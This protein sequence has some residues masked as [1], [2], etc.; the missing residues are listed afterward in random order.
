MFPAIL[1]EP[2]IVLLTLMCLTFTALAFVV[3]KTFTDNYHSKI[4]HP[5]TYNSRIIYLGTNEL[6][7]T[8]F[9][10]ELHSRK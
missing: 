6:N 3:Q 4:K 7:T 1:K 2:I 10:V 5:T 8:D 9:N